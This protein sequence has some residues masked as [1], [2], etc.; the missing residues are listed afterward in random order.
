MNKNEVRELIL[1]DDMEKVAKWHQLFRDPAFIPKYNMDWDE[2]R[3]LPMKRLRKVAQS[4]LGSGKDFFKNPKNIFLAHEF[5]AQVDSGTV[6]KFTVQYNLFGGSIVALHTDRHSYL[7]DKI[8]SF[9]IVGCF[10]LTELG[11]GN[12]AVKMETTVTYD[13]G[14]KEFVVNTPTTLAQKYW[15]TNGFKHSNH[16]LVFGQTIV[17]GKNEGVGAFLVPIRDSNLKEKNG[18]QIIDMGAK[19]GANGVDNAALKFDNVR[20]P[21]VNMMNKFTDVDD[22]GKFSSEIKG[23]NQRFFQ[24]TERLLSGR[25]C[26]ASMCVGA[27]R[28]CL[29]IAITYAKQRMAVGPKGESNA[30]IFSYQL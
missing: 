17:G 29:Y 1:G 26:I 6:I 27:S 21:R 9:D 5:L 10:C 11:F 28:S 2:T 13:E 30:P 16:A 24:V 12:N 20:I 3:D 18:M 15:I 22:Q 8:D 23:L 7:F 14:T 4:G 19:L 25:L